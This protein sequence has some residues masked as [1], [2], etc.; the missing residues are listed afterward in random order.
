EMFE[1]KVD[2]Q[3]KGPLSVAVPGEVAG[4][5]QAWTNNGRRVQWKQLVEPSIKLARDGFVVGPHLAFA[6]STNEEKIR[7]DTGL[8]SVFVIG[9]KL[10]TKGDT[11][12][13]IELAET[14]KKV[15]QNGMKA[16]YQDDVAK[17]LVN[18]LMK[19]GGNMTLEDL[20]NYK[21]NVTVAMVVNDVMG[22]K[23]QGLWPPSSGTPGFA[24][25]MNIL[26]QYKY[27]DGIDKNLFL[28]R[29]IEAIKFM[30]AARMDLGD[31]AFVEGIS[32]VVKNMTSKS[33]A[34]KIQEKISD[35]KTY[36]PDYYRSKVYVDFYRYYILNNQMADFSVTSEESAPPANY[37]EANK[38]PLSSMMPLIIT[39]D[40]E[41][42]GVIGAS[43]GI[44]IIPAVIQ[45]FL[46]HFVLNM[47]PLE[48]VKSP[49]V[50]HK[51]E[52][53]QVL[54]ENWTVYNQ[55]HILLNK[56][57]RDFLK[58]KKHELVS[59]SMG[60][61]VQFVVQDRQVL[62]AEMFE[63][64]VDKQQKGP[65]SVAVPG[66]VA[67]LYQAWTNNGRRVQWKQLVEPSIKLARDGFVVGPHLAFALSTN[68]EK[69]RNDTGLKSVFVIGD[70][71]LTKGDTCKNIELAETLKKVAQ[72]GM[73]AFY[74][75]DVAKNL[76]NDL[77]KAGGNM[78]LEDLRNY[79]VNVTDAMV[80]NDVM[81]FKLQGMW[82]P[83]SGTPGFAMVMNIL[84][85]YK[86]IYGIDKNL[87]LHRVI[88]AIKFMLAARMDLGDPAFVEGISEP[89]YIL[90]CVINRYK[91]LKDEGTSHLVDK[92]RNV[93]SM[94]TTVNY[95][96]G[97]GF[98]STSAG[99]ILNN[100]MAD[101]SITSEKS[102]PPA[103]YIEANKRPLSSMMPLI[104]TKD[105][106]LVGVIGASGGIYIIPAVIQVFLN[107]FVL[108]MSPLE[109][110]KS[111]RVYHKLEPNQVLYENW[112]VYN[113]DHI[114]LNKETRDFLKTKKHELV[115]TS[116]GATVQF[117]V[118]DR[119]VLTAVS[120][121][122][123]DGKPAAA[124]AAPTLKIETHIYIFLII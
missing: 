122:R 43:G 10:L 52:P 71:L 21:V 91:Q 49:R 27:I 12:K 54:Y 32:E 67:G 18:D 63:G 124:A 56:E 90:T 15:A 47:S 94:T 42:V 113:Q 1:G 46:N 30:L 5:Y 93:V 97:S 77:M 26:E 79:K 64:K 31:P 85:Q 40:N 23:L 116:M 123:K 87:F 103:N 57:T 98:M 68:E 117:V 75:D 96:F 50:Y 38:R 7:N 82:P 89:A 17:N 105:N 41:L 3:Q 112:T 110:V 36:P 66:E 29:V 39:K 114:L 111:P 80:V 6:L 25:V 11:C 58:T 4:L 65:L 14:L 118:Q 101:F 48:A 73:K 19:A 59:T 37:I 44:Y 108:N 9:D 115:S 62:T 120:D 86:D 106:E 76:V 84:E 69:I 16:F 51:L 70:K 81:G 53:N 20:R 24:M 78:T 13:N 102:A 33:W 2:K 72:N 61:T 35:D 121:L 104:I 8:K 109:A 55:D 45:V 100:Q 60:A 74:Q 99:I 95:A 34:Q 28:H 92:D 83:S 88:E 22:F 119:Q 107:H